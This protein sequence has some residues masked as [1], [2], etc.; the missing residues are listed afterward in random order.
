MSDEYVPTTDTIKRAYVSMATGGI[1]VLS[2]TADEERMLARMRFDRWLATHDAD[3]TP[4]VEEVRDA[5]FRDDQD[6]LDF[7]RF[8]ADVQAKALEAWANAVEAD[9][10]ETQFEGAGDYYLTLARTRAASLRAP[11]EGGGGGE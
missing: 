6:V 2:R 3:Y 7:D 11:H 1:P 10:S 4:S 9:E 8:L 5:W